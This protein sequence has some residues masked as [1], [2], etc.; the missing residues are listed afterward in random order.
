MVDWNILSAVLEGDLVLDDLDLI[1]HS[2]DASIF[3]IKP[4]AIIYPKTSSDV[5][6][7][8]K[9]VNSHKN[10]QENLSI[11]ARSAGTDMS[12]GALN[13]SIIVDFTKYMNKAWPIDLNQKNIE[14]EPGIF[15]RDFEILTK[16]KGLL[17]P[18]F[19]ASKS[20]AALGGMVANNSAGEKSLKYGKTDKFV[21]EL[22]VILSDGQKYLIK[23]LTQTELDQKI[24]QDD[25]EGKIYKQIYDLLE[26]NYD[27]IHTAKPKVTKNSAGYALWNVWNR[28][29]FDLTQLFVGSQG[30]LGVIT[31]AKLRLVDLEKETRMGVIFLKTLTD[32]PDVSK[33]LLTINPGSIEAVDDETLKL[34]LKYLPEIAKRSKQ[35]FWKLAY[36]FLPE[37]MLGAGMLRLPKII[38]LVEITEKDEDTVN[39]KVDQLSQLIKDN[40]WRGMI[41][42]E[43]KEEKYWTIRRES[44]NLLRQHSAKL[45]AAPF[46]DDVSVPIDNMSEF[47]KEML[48]ILKQYHIHVTLAGHAGEGNFHVIPLLNFKDKSEIEK[49]P[50]VSD[51][52]YDLVLKYGGSITG[53][54][55]DGLIRSRYLPKQFGPEVF[56]LFE[57]TKKI[58]DPKNIFN[59]GKKVNFDQNFPVDK[60]RT[61]W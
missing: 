57:K 25:F 3:E 59:P 9:F 4:Q 38:V 34:A 24:S 5:E 31:K 49:I 20:I 45:H 40:H 30:T 55:N 28:E 6:E 32:L 58:F 51:L 52:V 12:G 54:H 35:N 2:H 8:V 44:F 22:E 33:K 42:G 56:N 14:V 37:F 61:D 39:S 36:E 18:A 19:P 16:E 53:E 43:G 41:L 17:Y 60:I 48:E 13:D 29:K 10:I 50:V 23:P 7:I 21:E 26:S 11:T 27:A 15:Y 1:K 47:L 46:I